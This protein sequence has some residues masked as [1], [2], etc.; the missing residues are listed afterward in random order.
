MKPWAVSMYR[1]GHDAQ[2]FC[3]GVCVFVWFLELSPEN[4]IVAD[5]GKLPGA[6]QCK[7]RT[8]K[9]FRDYAGQ[10]HMHVCTH[11]YWFL[12]NIFLKFYHQSNHAYTQCTIQNMAVLTV[13]VYY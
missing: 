6:S 9:A 1:V 2:E 4:H 11:A 8:A 7:R 3:F 5:V 13:P 12:G 10:T